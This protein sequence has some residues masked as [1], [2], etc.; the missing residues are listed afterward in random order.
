MRSISK[1]MGLRLST[2]KRNSL[3]D[4]KRLRIPK[5]YSKIIVCKMRSI[6][7]EMGLRLST[8]KRN[9]LQDEKRLK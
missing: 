8:Q 6:S 4:E 1:E 3:Q 5:K 7:K 9:S 2:Q